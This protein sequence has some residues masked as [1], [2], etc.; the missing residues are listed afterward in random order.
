MMGCLGK[1]GQ[2]TFYKSIK[3]GERTFSLGSFMPVKIWPDMEF[4]SI[5]DVQLLWSDKN[6][7][8]LCSLRL[9]FLPENTPDGRLSQH[10]EVSFRLHFLH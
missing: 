6:N 3:I 1:H 10:G 7:E 9:Y 5:A 2:Y 8:C 4:L